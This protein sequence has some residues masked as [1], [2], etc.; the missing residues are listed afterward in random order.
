MLSPLFAGKYPVQFSGNSQKAPSPQTSKPSSIKEGKKPADHF[1]R[2]AAEEE[3]YKMMDLVDKHLVDFDKWT[4]SLG[5]PGRP[6]TPPKLPSGLHTAQEPY[7]A[8]E[9]INA[10]IYKP[11]KSKQD[12]IEALI[13][14]AGRPLSEV[15]NE[16]YEKRKLQQA[17]QGSSGPKA[18]PKK[19]LLRRLCC[20]G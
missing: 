17:T 12:N 10:G 4:S 13:G 20:I 1:S 15:A 11:T 19:S 8:L 18:K 6:P 14:N 5:G 2:N 3:A 7:D 16:E 9:A